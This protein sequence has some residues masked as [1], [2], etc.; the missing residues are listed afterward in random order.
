[1]SLPKLKFTWRA[2]GAFTALTAFF[3][4][5]ALIHSYSEKW[6]KNVDWWVQKVAQDGV[7]LAQGEYLINESAIFNVTLFFAVLLS[8]LLALVG[9]VLDRPKGEAERK[10]AEANYQDM[11][12]RAKETSRA[13]YS[14]YKPRTD[15]KTAKIVNTISKDGSTHVTREI[16]LF[17][18]DLPAHQ[19]ELQLAGDKQFSQQTGHNAIGFRVVDKDTD[20]ELPWIPVGDAPTTK[21]IMIYFPEMQKGQTKKLFIEYEWEGYA[22]DLIDKGRTDFWW[23]NKSATPSNTAH[24]RHEWIFEKGMPAVT[25]KG[26]SALSGTSALSSERTA[27]N[28]QVWVF[29][30]LDSP[31]DNEKLEFRVEFDR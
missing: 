15:L 30:D 4:G 7:A 19:I 24:I 9:V 21:E 27:D 11:L 10:L 3:G 28:C 5:V 14:Q 17:C 13:M 25:V 1:M 20:K 18:P 8:V 2:I 22:A 6:S 12:D 16:E 29:E 26:V 23:A 31:S